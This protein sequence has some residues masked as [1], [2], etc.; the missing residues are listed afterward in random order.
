ML[1]QQPPAGNCRGF[2]VLPALFR[3]QTVGTI[4]FPRRPRRLS[5][6]YYLCDGDALWRIPQRIH[7]ALLSGE[8]ALPQYANS[9]QKVVE[10]FIWSG[11][12]TARRVE[13]RGTVFSFNS[14]GLI[15]LAEAAETAAIA[16]EGSK[17]RRLDKR[18]LDIGPVIRTR[19]LARERSWKPPAS[20]LRAI[21]ADVN[22]NGKI[23]ALCLTQP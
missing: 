12:T 14:A 16:I 1:D 2:F 9:K 3:T 21:I 4:P 19:R 20:V 13:A 22:G 11:P 5:L 6:R 18:V 7:R 10:V 15:D 17:P 8:A 23:R